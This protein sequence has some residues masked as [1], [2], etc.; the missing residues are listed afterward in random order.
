MLSVVVDVVVESSS[1][2]SCSRSDSLTTCHVPPNDAMPLPPSAPACLSSEE[3]VQ[4]VTVERQLV[5]AVAVQASRG[6]PSRRCPWR[7]WSSCRPWPGA[8]TRSTG[9]SAQQVLGGLR[10]SARTASCRATSTRIVALSDALCAAL[11]SGLGFLVV[12]AVAS[13]ARPATATSASA[14]VS[15]HSERLARRG[16]FDDIGLLWRWGGTPLKTP[17]GGPAFPTRIFSRR[18][19][20]SPAG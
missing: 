20:P 11:T 18:R 12:L 15:S 5:E 16:R 17:P 19:R 8:R 3:V 10:A 13:A 6:I 1:S 2:W 14:V 9:R 4:G 7:A